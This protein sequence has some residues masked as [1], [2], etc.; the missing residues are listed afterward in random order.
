M[1]TLL[2]L[3]SLVRVPHVPM[4]NIEKFITSNNKQYGKEQ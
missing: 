3:S 2:G 4:K 1:K